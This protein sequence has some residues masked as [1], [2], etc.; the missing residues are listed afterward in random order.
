[1]YSLGVRIWMVTVRDSVLVT[2][3]K[4]SKVTIWPISS[5]T[6]NYN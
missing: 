2:C 5:Q 6:H 3:S 1:V 4:V